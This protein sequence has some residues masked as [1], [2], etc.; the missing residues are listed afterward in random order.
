MVNLFAPMAGVDRILRGRQR[1]DML[2]VGCGNNSTLDDVGPV[3]YETIQTVRMLRM[4]S[5]TTDTAMPV[6]ALH[7][8]SIPSASVY[9]SCWNRLRDTT[10]EDNI[11][12]VR[13][14]I[15]TQKRVTYQQIRTNLSI[16]MSEVHKILH[17]HLSI[18]KLCT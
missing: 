3:P 15:E 7:L 14:M 4:H 1:R 2:C 13:L 6:L 16:G 10:A 5:F 12:A 11:S 17:E 9:V 8:Y 18:R